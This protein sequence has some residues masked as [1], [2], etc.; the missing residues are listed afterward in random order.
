MKNRKHTVMALLLAVLV[1]VTGAAAGSLVQPYA[2]EGEKRVFI[3]DS[4]TVGMF[5][6]VH[7]QYHNDLLARRGNEVWSAWS[8]KGISEMPYLV[9]RARKEAGGS[10][11]G[12]KVY[13]LLG[14]NNLREH[15]N[16]R[17]MALRY[18]YELHHTDWNGAK[19]YFVSVNPVCENGIRRGPGTNKKIEEFNRY[20]RLGARKLDTGR[21]NQRNHFRGYTYIDTASRVPEFKEVVRTGEYTQDPQEG[22]TCV[23]HKGYVHDG[24][25]YIKPVYEKIYRILVEY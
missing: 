22:H 8:G 4:R 23:Y 6:A 5:E 14:V 11:K 9:N 2:E 7:G 10:F 21:M 25:H 20:M 3:G 24:L 17:E 13:I 15:D 16:P 12:Y 19:V 18:L 1:I